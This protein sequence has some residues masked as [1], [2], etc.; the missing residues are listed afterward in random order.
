MLTTALED[1]VIAKNPCR[2]RGGSTAA[3]GKK[4]VPPTDEEFDTLTATIDKRYLALVVLCGVGGLRFGEASALQAKDIVIEREPNKPVCARISVTKGVVLVGGKRSTKSTKNGDERTIPIYGDGALI[5]AEQVKGKIGQ[6]LLFTARGS[7]D[8]LPQS[9][10]FRRW[11]K[12]RKA[13]GRPDMPVH[14]LRHYAGTSYSQIGATVKETMA[15]LGHRTERAAMRYQHAGGRDDELAMRMSQRSKPDASAEKSATADSHDAGEVSGRKRDELKRS[16]PGLSATPTAGTTVKRVN[17][18]GR[19]YFLRAR[20][21]D[22]RYAQTDIR[23]SRPSRRERVAMKHNHDV[24][25]PVRADGTRRKATDA[26]KL[27][28]W[29]WGGRE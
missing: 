26:A 6:K 17:C 21:P 27:S 24:R 4:V 2:I 10:F 16:A 15:R 7:E 8:Y 23:L 28:R 9:T 3:T 11:D 18:W 1:E 14:A 12:A 5:I 19:T 29:I 13:A 25:S 20:L 22:G